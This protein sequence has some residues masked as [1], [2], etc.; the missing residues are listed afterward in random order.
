[1]RMS[2]RMTWRVEHKGT[3][4]N[5]KEQH[6]FPP[7]FVPMAG[8]PGRDEKRGRSAA[9]VAVENYVER[10]MISHKQGLVKTG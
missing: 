5:R 4:E 9:N 1:M 10:P 7:F 3:E 8:K 2:M 6:F